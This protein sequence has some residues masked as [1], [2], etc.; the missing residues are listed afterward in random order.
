MQKHRTAT[1]QQTSETWS[2]QYLDSRITGPAPAGYAEEE[3]IFASNERG[4]QGRLE[5]RVRV[6]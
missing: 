5:G 2:L 1:T 3:N 6:V 4:V